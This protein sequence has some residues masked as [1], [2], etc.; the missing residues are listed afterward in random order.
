[1]TNFRVDVP[2]VWFDSGYMLMSLKIRIFTCLVYP[3]ETCSADTLRFKLFLHA[4]LKPAR[5]HR[6]SRER[7]NDLLRLVVVDALQLIGETAFHRP[8]T[9]PHFVPDLDNAVLNVR[10]SNH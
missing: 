5:S 2:V 8:R 3:A 6:D 9:T 10:G 7:R 1:M 4:G